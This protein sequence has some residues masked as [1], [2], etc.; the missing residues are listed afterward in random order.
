MDKLQL[1]KIGGNII[2]NPNVLRDFLKDFAALQGPKI[3]VHGGGKE[4]TSLAKK[5]NVEV[6]LVDGRRITN[7]ANLELITMVYAGKINKSVVAQLQSFS[8]NALG[9]SGADGNAY[10]AKKRAVQELDYGFV[11][12]LTKINTGFFKQILEQNIC[13]ICCAV[14]HDQQ[15]QLLNTNADTIAA[16]IAVALSPYFEVILTYCFE[17]NGVLEN[18]HD[19][20]SVIPVIDSERYEE[21]KTNGIIAEGMLPKLHNCF[22]ALEKGVQEIRIGSPKIFSKNNRFTKIQK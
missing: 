10:T 8:C 11:G 12:D 17:K 5:M 14:S 22:D 9:I 21:L 3:L 7:A 4:A 16:A 6:A 15:G 20:N 13:P 19:P 18:L 1:V 2:E